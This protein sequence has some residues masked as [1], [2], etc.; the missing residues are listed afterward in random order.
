MYALRHEEGLG[1]VLGFDPLP[2][3]RT[4]MTKNNAISLVA[5]IIKMVK[6]I[7]CLKY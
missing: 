2:F 1:G 7:I 5:S 3:S 4:F 6:T